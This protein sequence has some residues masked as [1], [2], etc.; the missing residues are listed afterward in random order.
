MLIFRGS[1]AIFD[2]EVR[3]GLAIGTARS[4]LRV[5]TAHRLSS[6]SRG[7]LAWQAGPGYIADYWTPQRGV[8]TFAP[9]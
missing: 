5:R 7:T 4:T 8:P 3:A 6:R 1:A 2:I 9:S